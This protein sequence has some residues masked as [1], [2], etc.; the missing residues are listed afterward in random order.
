MVLKTRDQR[1]TFTWMDWCTLLA[2]GCSAGAYFV[3]FHADDSHDNLSV[4]LKS[5]PILALVVL[6]N[7]HQNHVGSYNG[8]LSAGLLFCALG[9]V[10]L[11]LEKRPGNSIFF[12]AGLG[13]FLVG[14]LM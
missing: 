13:A 2:A 6:V 9:D 7:M 14:H 12:I 5:F 8:R 11:E 4:V 10:A 1:L 3:K